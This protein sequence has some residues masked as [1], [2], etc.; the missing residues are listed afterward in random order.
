MLP[1][2]FFCEK[3]AVE[4]G[5]VH[6]KGTKR[7][8]RPLRAAPR[9]P[10]ASDDDE[11]AVRAGSSQFGIGRTTEGWTRQLCLVVRPRSHP[12]RLEARSDGAS[13]GERDARIW[14]AGE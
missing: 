4:D 1:D 2:E 11:A 3:W 5:R 6:V 7:E 8:A 12:S 10:R 14:L 9:R 13:G